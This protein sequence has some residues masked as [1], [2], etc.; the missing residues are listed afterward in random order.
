[1]I[2]GVGWVMNRIRDADPACSAGEA[3]HSAAPWGRSYLSDKLHGSW[4]VWSRYW[5]VGKPSAVEVEHSI[6]AR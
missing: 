3:L 5:V 4:P 2:V 6:S 1:M